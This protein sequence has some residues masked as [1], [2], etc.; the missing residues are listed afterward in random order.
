MA[1][2]SRRGAER[3]E[4]IAEARR[5]PRARYTPALMPTAPVASHT[6]AGR[7]EATRLAVRAREDT[8]ARPQRTPRARGER[9]VGAR[10]IALAGVEL[11]VEV[12]A[13]RDG[14]CATW[15]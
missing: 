3:V 12:D 1:P 6:V 2:S 4:A 9:A 15:S 5:D 11:R 8:V 7:V 13:R 10:A 14:E